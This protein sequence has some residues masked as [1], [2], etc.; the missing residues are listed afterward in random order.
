M[1]V[2][3]FA[4]IML[5][6]SHVAVHKGMC[7]PQ[8]TGIALVRSSKYI[9]IE[10]N[11]QISLLDIDECAT[12]NGDCQHICSNIAGSRICSCNSGYRLNSDDETCRGE[13]G[14]VGFVKAT[15]IQV[16]TFFFFMFLRY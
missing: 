5:G 7:W 2:L 6:A 4:L 12:N 10:T 11:N 13:T 1:G 14:W 8:M 9:F 3:R 16:S 15:E